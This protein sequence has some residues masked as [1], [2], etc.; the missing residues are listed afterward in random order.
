MKSQSN[1]LLR[2]SKNLRGA[3]FFQALYFFRGIV[4]N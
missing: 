3:P 1:K 2:I 4:Y